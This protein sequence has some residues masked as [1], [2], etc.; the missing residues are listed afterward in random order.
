[1]ARIRQLS[2]HEVGH[3]IGLGHNYASNLNGRSSVMDYP[4]MWVK[5]RDGELDLS[6]AY[7]VGVGEWDIVSI[8]YGY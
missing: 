6:E 4:A 3:T 2:V 5:E 7:E 8:N 1:M